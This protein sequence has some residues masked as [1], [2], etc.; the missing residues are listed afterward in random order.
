MLRLS[1]FNIRTSSTQPNHPWT[2]ILP[3]VQRFYKRS[4]TLPN[5]GS[6]VHPV[7]AFIGDIFS[8]PKISNGMVAP[9]GAEYEHDGRTQRQRPSSFGI[10]CICEAVVEEF[11]D[12]L[13]RPPAEVLL[14]SNVPVGFRFAFFCKI[15]KGIQS[16]LV[17]YMDKLNIGIT[18]EV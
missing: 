3:R 10:K 14:R 15:K 6:P 17:G 12:R 2:L 16:R 1:D 13:W 11:L 9:V 18:E 5:P 7:A 4:E 8:P